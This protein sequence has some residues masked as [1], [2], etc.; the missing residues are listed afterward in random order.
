[1]PFL[2][3]LSS[4]FYNSYNLGSYFPETIFKIFCMESAFK[5]N[6][7]YFASKI[8]FDDLAKYIQKIWQAKFFGILSS[9]RTHLKCF[10]SKI[11]QIAVGNRRIFLVARTRQERRWWLR[12]ENED[13]V[14]PRKVIQERFG[15]ITS[16]SSSCS[17]YYR[18]LSPVW[19][20]VCVWH[21]RMVA[22]CEKVPGT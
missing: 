18:S 17:A 1:M 22:D 4:L 8:I 21:R 3:V 7:K 6:L 15:V 16:A 12:S 14:D 2:S 10:P 13:R 19:T 20:T 5:R 11:W 9:C